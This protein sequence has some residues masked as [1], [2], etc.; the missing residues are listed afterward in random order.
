MRAPLTA[1]GHLAQD[2]AADS[3]HGNVTVRAFCVPALN[4]MLTRMQE[5]R[6]ATD[7]P[8]SGVVPSPTSPGWTTESSRLIGFQR[9]PAGRRSRSPRKRGTGNAACDFDERHDFQT[10]GR[11]SYRVRKRVDGII[12]L[13]RTGQMLD[14]GTMIVL[15]RSGA[16]GDVSRLLAQQR[17]LPGEKCG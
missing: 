7:Y 5:D 8:A 13:T 1:L 15:E 4:R 16:S 9:A 6:T 17:S 3:W 10:G 2:D 12:D 11:Q 14:E